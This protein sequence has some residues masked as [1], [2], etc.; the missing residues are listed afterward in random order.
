MEL[1]LKKDGYLSGYV[2]LSPWD[3]SGGL[4]TSL[5]APNYVSSTVTSN[6]YYYTDQRR[7][8]W[9]IPHPANCRPS[10][11]AAFTTSSTSDG[12]R[13]SATKTC[14]NR[15]TRTPIIQKIVRRKW[16][17][18]GHTFRK[19]PSNITCQAIEWNL[20]GDMEAILW[21]RT[22]DMWP[23]LG[24][25]QEHCPKPS[26]VENCCWDPMFH[27]ESKGFSK[28]V[29]GWDVLLNE[30]FPHEFGIKKSHLL[31]TWPCLFLRCA[32]DYLQQTYL[33]QI[34]YLAD[35]IKSRFQTGLL[36]KWLQLINYFQQPWSRVSLAWQ[37]LKITSNW[38]HKKM[39][40]P[41]A[42]NTPKYV[43]I[44]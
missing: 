38:Y 32:C 39:Q 1:V 44:L 28:S 25:S 43:T 35:W 23:E 6:S 14:G 26:A 30:D 5:K 24:G 41:A 4:Q 27:K 2:L 21:G 13:R 12:Q 36:G 37:K 34:S 22:E 10:W 8:G 3:Q 17:W 40:M 33:L 15:Q 42:C 31:Y 9:Q 7:G 18:I 20:K 16:R 29:S 19:A 11:T